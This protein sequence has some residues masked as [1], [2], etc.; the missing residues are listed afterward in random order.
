MNILR[1]INPAIFLLIGSATF[2]GLNFHLAKI[3][4]V[5]V[6]F[7]EAGFWRY[8]LGVGFLFFLLLRSHSWPSISQIRKGMKGILLVGLIGL[9]GFNQF[10]F[11]GMKYTSALNAALIVSLNPATTLLMSHW[12]LKSTITRQQKTGMLLALVGVVY[13]LTKGHPTQLMEISWSL[14][15]LLILGANILFALQNV[16]VKIYVGTFNNRVFT[17]LT[18][19]VCLLAFILMLPVWGMNTPALSHADFW[20]SILGIGILGTSLAYLFWN[21]GIQQVGLQMPVCI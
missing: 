13:L 17:F 20:L 2:W 4:L 19:A 8:L 1:K 14:G 12:I 9:F 6:N 10:F 18:N 7:I 3:M 16:W 11:L 15:D 5:Y 21:K